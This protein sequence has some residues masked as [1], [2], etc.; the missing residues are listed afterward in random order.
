MEDKGELA[1]HRFPLP[2]EIIVEILSR[3]P[4]KSLCRFRCVPKPW[5][6]LIS[7][8]KFIALHAKKALED[9][10]VL[11]RRRRVIFNVACRGLYSSYGPR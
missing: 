5:V 10:E 8:L 11:L 6:S 2:S 1:G 9:K 3:L 4:V 7:N